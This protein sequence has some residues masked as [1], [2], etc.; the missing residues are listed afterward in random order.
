MGK[1]IEDSQKLHES[2][3]ASVAV[4]RHRYKG[5]N[6]MT[7]EM[8]EI[9]TVRAKRLFGDLIAKVIYFLNILARLQRRVNN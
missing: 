8:K 6:L 3:R 1:D 5:F 2:L 4:R 7:P 9:I